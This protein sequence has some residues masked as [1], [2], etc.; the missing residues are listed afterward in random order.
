MKIK[1][2]KKAT[3]PKLRKEAFKLWSEIV[4]K[5]GYC[6]LCG[7]K[8]RDLKPNGKPV[9]LNAHHIIGRENHAL[10]F[11]IKNGCSLCQ[12]CHKYSKTGAHKG[13][14]VFSDWFMQK[15]PEKYQYLLQSYQ[16]VVELNIEYM[17][18][19]IESLKKKL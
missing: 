5:G 6:E 12:N 8:Y 16:K 3:L 1:K 11:D 19:I 9:I 4:R 15:Y 7:V 10:A 2:T 14:I 18:N 13:G 17:Q